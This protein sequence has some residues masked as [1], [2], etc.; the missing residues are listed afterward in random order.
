MK[1][2][3]GDKVKVIHADLYHQIDRDDDEEEAYQEYKDVVGMIGTITVAK[4]TDSGVGDNYYD[5]EIK[6][7]TRGDEE[8]YTFFEKELAPANTNKWKGKRR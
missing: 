6:G 4:G 2:K 7:K 1:Y 8:D 5:T 3:K